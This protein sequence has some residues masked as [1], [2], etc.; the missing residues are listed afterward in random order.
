[1]SLS[2]E[3]PSTSPAPSGSAWKKRCSPP[4]SR[5]RRST[6]SW[7]RPTRAAPASSSPASIRSASRRSTIA[8]GSIT[9]RSRAPPSSARQAVEGP[10]P[11]RHRGGRTSD[12]PVA[13]E[14]ERTLA[15]QAMPRRS[16][17]MSASRDCG[18]DPADRGDPGSSVVI[19]AAGMDAALPSVLG[20]L[21]AGAVIAVPTSVGYGVAE[22]GRAARPRRGAGEL[23]PRHRG[24]QQSTTATA[25][26]A[27]PCACSTQHPGSR[28]LPD[29]PSAGPA[30]ATNAS[31]ASLLVCRR[32]LSQ[33]RHHF[34]K[35]LGESPW[36]VAASAGRAALGAGLAVTTGAGRP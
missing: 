17:P 34:A 4:A 18:A 2:D 24:R 36:N 23:R 21:V 5:R 12:V 22:G 15:Y 31:S 9:A 6:P 7:R 8:T 29:G 32:S 30:L 20:G 27:R 13:R 14:A 19:C 1:M 10:G 16:S 33:I 3:S 25:P 28:R 26:P 11:H 35:S